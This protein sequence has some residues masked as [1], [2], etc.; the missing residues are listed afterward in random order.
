MYWLCARCLCGFADSRWWWVKLVRKFFLF[1]ALLGM[2]FFSAFVRAENLENLIYMEGGSGK[3]IFAYRDGETNKGISVDILRLIWNDIGIEEQPIHFY[4]WARAYKY[5]KEKS[6]HV[7]L[8]ISK[9]SEREAIFKWVGPYTKIRFGIFAL[10]DRNVI[11]KDLEDSKGLTIGFMRGDIVETLLV[12]RG[13]AGNKIALTKE[14][15]IIKMLKS[16]RID[17]LGLSELIFYETVKEMNLNPDDFEL[18]STLKETGAYF[19]F[20]KDV[21]DALIEQFQTS[22]DNQKDKVKAIVNSYLKE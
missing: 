10:K 21:S 1:I 17:L 13:F 14:S 19:G 4:P 2:C 7:I 12:E 22:L 9:T 16:G 6:R 11:V 3:S 15:Q 5:L 20:H 18:V 8:G